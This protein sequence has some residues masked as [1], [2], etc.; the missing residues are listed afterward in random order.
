V[1]HGRQ[2]ESIAAGSAMLRSIALPAAMEFD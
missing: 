1:E 2:E